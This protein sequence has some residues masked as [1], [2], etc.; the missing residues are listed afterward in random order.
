MYSFEC[1]I[2]KLIHVS[3]LKSIA[4]VMNVRTTQSA[5]CAVIKNQNFLSYYLRC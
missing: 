4:A 5:R 2:V 3:M 1:K